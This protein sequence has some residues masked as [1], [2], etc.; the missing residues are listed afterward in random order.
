MAARG[1]FLPEVESRRRRIA[2]SARIEHVESKA[3]AL[4]TARSAVCHFAAVAAAITSISALATAAAL[5]S[6]TTAA[7]AIS[8]VATAAST[9]AAALRAISTTATPTAPTAVI[10]DRNLSTLDAI[11]DRL[12]A[13]GLMGLLSTSAQRGRLRLDGIVDRDDFTA[14]IGLFGAAHRRR[15]GIIRKGLRA[16]RL[17]LR[18]KAARRRWSI[19]RRRRRGAR[20]RRGSGRGGLVFALIV[21]VE[22]AGS[23][24]SGT[25]RNGHRL[26]H[27]GASICRS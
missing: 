14:E 20:S 11:V 1:R 4:A 3:A 22:K 7:A 18:L 25:H 27:T 23:E 13:A 21:V 2:G 10:V 24:V 5:A 8:T 9:A 6:L 12:Y 16:R 26:P 17:A 15:V 19:S